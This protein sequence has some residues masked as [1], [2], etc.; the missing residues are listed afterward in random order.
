MKNRTEQLFAVTAP[1]LEEVCASELLTLG[2]D[3]IRVVAGGVEFCGGLREIYQANLWLRSAS[4][5]LVRLDSIKCR[6]FPD[7]YRKGLRLPWGRFLR[8]G[9]A[10][11]VRA[12]S[13]SSRLNHSGRIAA[14]L[15]E[16]VDRALGREVSPAAGPQQLVLARFEDDV[17]Q[18][19]VDSSGE[20]LHRRGYRA[21]TAF[22]P[23]RETLAAG[24][25]LKL[26]WDGSAPLADPMCGSGT[27]VIEAALLAGN[28]APGLD[29]QFSFM[30]WPGFRQGLLD[31]LRLEARRAERPIRVPICGG[32]RHPEALAAARRNAARAGVETLVEL[33][34]QELQHFVAPAGLGLVVCNPPY[35]KRIGRDEDLRPLFR[36]LGALFRGHFPG[37][38]GAF[39][40][41]DDHLAKATGLPLQRLGAL[42]NGGIPVTLWMA[43][44]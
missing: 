22:A 34:Q 30:D 37:W 24:I 13:Q 26:G 32:E 36:A 42:H 27:F 6:D 15:A 35:G 38:R 8:P 40:C 17:C 39:I 44:L 16:A 4:R 33:C 31:A 5:I 2:M 12:S 20:L 11:Q 14:T 25:L 7:L 43:D 9:T 3:A 23:L 18:L 21:E 10:L 28:R 41:P 1:G 29:R 19:S